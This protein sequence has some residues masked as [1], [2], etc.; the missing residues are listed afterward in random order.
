MPNLIFDLLMLLKVHVLLDYP[1]TFSV[2]VMS[3]ASHIC[4]NSAAFSDSKA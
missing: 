1:L 2:S 3:L 4:P